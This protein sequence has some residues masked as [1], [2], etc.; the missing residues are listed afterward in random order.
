MKIAISTNDGLMTAPNFETSDGFLILTLIGGEIVKEEIRRKNKPALD[1]FDQVFSQLSDCSS[2]IVRE[3]SESSQQIF[4]DKSTPVIRTKEE[5]I[6]NVIVHYLEH[7]YREASN[8][9][10]CP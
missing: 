10:C 2:V 3:I 8:T 1:D 7:E 9:C 6:T 5:I 4:M